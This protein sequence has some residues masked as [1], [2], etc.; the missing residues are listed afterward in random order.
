[1]S[2]RTNKATLAERLQTVTEILQGQ[3][4]VNAAAKRLQ[5]SGSVSYDWLRAYQASGEE[6]LKESHT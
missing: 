1:M 3:T 5:V 6:G 4:S 2:V